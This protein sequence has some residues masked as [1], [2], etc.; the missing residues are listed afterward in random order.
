MRKPRKP[1]KA[2][3][4]IIQRRLES[5]DFAEDSWLYAD[6]KEVWMRFGHDGKP[7]IRVIPMRL[8]RKALLERGLVGPSK[9]S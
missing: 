1:D 8:L 7:I 6:N 9:E 4:R 5:F 2:R 3:E